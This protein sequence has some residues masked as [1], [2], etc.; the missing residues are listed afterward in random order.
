MRLMLPW[1]SLERNSTRY[2][3]VPCHNPRGRPVINRTKSS[4]LTVTSAS[5]LCRNDQPSCPDTE[6]AQTWCS[7]G[8]MDDQEARPWRSARTRTCP[9][10]RLINNPPLYAVRH[11]A[12]QMWNIAWWKP[13][14]GAVTSPSGATRTPYVRWSEVVQLRSRWRSDEF[15]QSAAAAPERPASR[16]T[17]LSRLRDGASRR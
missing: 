14:V 7:Q 6:H 8:G 3:W 10:E 2:S 11:A 9:A 12:C 13:P 15:S 1:I 17:S 5:A 16:Q 4:N